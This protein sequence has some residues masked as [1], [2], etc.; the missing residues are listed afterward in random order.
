MRTVAC[1]IVAA[2]I[3]SMLALVS[4]MAADISIDNMAIGPNPY[5]ER[6]LVARLSLKGEITKGDVQRLAKAIE[7]VD[8][9]AASQHSRCGVNDWSADRLIVLDLQSPGGLYPRAGRLRS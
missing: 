5:G 7:E 8:R 9:A 4:A 6:C 1:Q 3:A 2:A